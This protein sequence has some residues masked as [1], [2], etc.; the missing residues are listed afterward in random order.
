MQFYF[1]GRLLQV[2]EERHKKASVGGAL[3]APA[4]PLSSCQTLLGACD[5]VF[6]GGMCC[7]CVLTFWFCRSLCVCVHSI[8]HDRVRKNALVQRHQWQQHWEIRS[9]NFHL[10]VHVQAHLHQNVH[11]KVSCHVGMFPKIHWATDLWTRVSLLTELALLAL[12][13]PMF[14]SRVHEE[15]S[16]VC[17]CDD[18]SKQK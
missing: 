15:W 18:A 12:S 1:R 5:C 14:P 4:L 8:G 11:L 16:R 17:W 6:V 10:L 13:S 2:W 9:K 3:A 7:F